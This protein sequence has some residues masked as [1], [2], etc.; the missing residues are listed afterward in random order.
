[1]SKIDYQPNVRQEDF[2]RSS[3]DIREDIAKEGENISQTV[4]QIGER[5]KDKL[6]WR[7]Y[8]KQSPYWTL[9]AAAGLG[10]FV[11]RMCRTRTT[12]NERIMH[13]IAGE[14][15]EALGTLRTQSAGAGLIKVTLVGVAAKVAAGWIKDAS[16]QRDTAE[17]GTE[18]RQNAV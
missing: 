6:D 18:N 8:V 12:A 4:E 10:F 15:H 14:I 5:I 7:E 13:S 3:E 9:G 1:M 2:E 16:R 17:S 11:S